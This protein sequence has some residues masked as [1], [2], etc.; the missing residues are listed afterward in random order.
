MSGVKHGRV[1][2]PDRDRGC[3][4]GPPRSS[5]PVE[6][7]GPEA[8]PNFGQSVPTSP[9]GGFEGFAWRRGV[10]IAVMSYNDSGEIPRAA[11]HLDAARDV[12]RAPKPPPRDR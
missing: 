1:S 2:W 9:A 4:P 8:T 11:G 7:Q 5:D 6:E 12:R 10:T 3:R